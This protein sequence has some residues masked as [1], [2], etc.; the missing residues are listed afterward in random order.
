MKKL[1]IFDASNYM[2]RAFFASPHMTNSVGFPTNA[3]HFYTAMLLSVIRRVNPD[4]IALAHE[5]KGPKFRHK[6]YSQ[7]KGNRQA[8]PDELVQQFPWFRRITDALGLCAYDADGYEADDVI[9]TLTQQALQRNYNVIIASSDKDLMQLVRRDGER[10]T[11]IMLD[12][13]STKSTKD[14]YR[15]ITVDD[16]FKR[17]NV[18]PECVADVLALSGDTADNIPGCKGIGEKTAGKLIAQYGSLEN[19]MAKRNEIKKPAQKANLDAF[20]PNAELS[21]KLVSLVYDVP[22]SF[23]ERA[24]APDA[25]AVTQLFS[26]LDL[27][28][29]LVDVLGKTAA[30][31]PSVPKVTVNDTAQCPSDAHT[32]TKPSALDETEIA[33]EA[34]QRL[35][36][37]SLKTDDDQNANSPENAVEC[38]PHIPLEDDSPLGDF[39]PCLPVILKSEQELRQYLDKLNTID[40]DDK[41]RVAIFPIA[42]NADITS[43]EWIGMAC[44]SK[45]IAFY[46]PFPKKQRTLF[47]ASESNA[48]N[49]QAIF[50]DFLCDKRFKKCVYNVKPCLHWLLSLGKTPDINAFFD[51]QIAAYILHPETSITFAHCVEQY[52]GTTNLE[53]PETWLGTGKKKRTPATIPEEDCANTAVNWAKLIYLMTPALLQKLQTTDLL[54]LYQTV[55]LPLAQTLAQM[56]F[57]GIKIDIGSLKNLAAAFDD[58]LRELDDKAH[59]FSDAPF[60]I[61]SPKDLGHFLFDVLKLVPATKKNKTHGLSTDQDTLESID[62]PIAQIILEYRSIAKLRSSYTESLIQLAN[63]HNARIHGNFNECVTATTR[64]SS[65]EPNLQN[66]PARTDLGRKIKR[67]FIP[68]KGH[69]FISA[70]YSQIELRV[71]AA[72]SKDPALVKAYRDDLDVHAL[73]ASALFSKN[74]DEVS[75]RERQIAKSINFGII[76]GMGAQ[77]LSRETGISKTE[78]KAFLEKFNAQFPTL[79]AWLE[80]NLENAKK[81]SE[82]RTILG[83]RRSI[84]EL[85]SPNKMLQALGER[86]VFNAPIQGSAS[87]IVKCAM[88]RLQKSIREKGLHA[89][90]LIQ[91]H[92]ELLLE[93]PDDEIE[94]AKN[95]LTEAMQNAIDI[96]IPLKIDLKIGKNWA[97]MESRND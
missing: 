9:A 19:L 15:I 60:N 18:A 67:A 22:V 4:C 80:S 3:L 31:D 36:P 14:S 94:D 77:K 78:A 17:F 1:L 11:V 90:L 74:I 84:P 66:I 71:L 55:D 34:T 5:K 32:E 2:F 64:L 73:T 93:T 37:L 58:E 40:E 96:G 72:L 50:A 42:A 88:L 26:A 86:I 95:A 30:I 83:H 25:N 56:E 87:D 82:I 44:F 7:Y 13:L 97:D 54:S 52:V 69:S 70:D 62:H 8:P 39:T 47:D 48:S 53:M 49:I 91:V 10:E 28:R 68:E 92:D 59:Q 27:H 23:L 89:R 57:D 21:K 24:Y 12:A 61:N 76:Y 20:A 35:L 38:A 45:D 16:V 43:P 41:P 63:P 85:Y 75:K 46:Y 81:T 79:R 51:V 65:S 29:L 33:P 6:L